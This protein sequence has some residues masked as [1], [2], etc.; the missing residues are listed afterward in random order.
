M[1]DIGFSELLVIG[2]VALLVLG[3]ERLPKA[4]R[5]F[6]ALLGR[7][8][9]MVMNV[10]ADL[11]REFAAGELARIEAELRA[12]ASDLRDSVVEPF[13]AA[14]QTLADAERLLG[15]PSSVST[16]VESPNL[17]PAGHE[18]EGVVAETA[19]VDERQPDLFAPA[20]PAAP[21]ANDR[22]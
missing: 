3:P 1:F 15:N 4:A 14:G 11:D 9:R 2:L 16:D 19:A 5:T 8:R 6:G 21:P 22:R 18:P 13:R 17:A 10:R 20:T 12:E 7:A